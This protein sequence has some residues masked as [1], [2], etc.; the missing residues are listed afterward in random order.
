MQPLPYDPYKVLKVAQ[1]V[2]PGPPSQ[3]LLQAALRQHLS[4][5]LLVGA[6]AERVLADTREHVPLTLVRLPLLGPPSTPLLGWLPPSTSLLLRAPPPS[7][8][9]E[10]TALLGLVRA[11]GEGGLDALPLDPNSPVELLPADLAAQVLLLLLLAPP[12]P[13]S[14]PPSSAPPTV[15]STPVIH[16]A[17]STLHPTPLRWGLFL[18]LLQHAWPGGGVRPHVAPLPP[19]Q[20]YRRHHAL[21]Q[22]LPALLY[23]LLARG[24]GSGLHLEAARRVRADLSRVRGHVAGIIPPLGPPLTP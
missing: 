13:S 14:G 7:T 18:A 1:E 12:S 17:P 10:G 2:A 16:V 22:H 3:A 11:L 20:H 9:A 23:S 21:R 4:P 8:P 24:A 15:E 5:A 19:G 6:M